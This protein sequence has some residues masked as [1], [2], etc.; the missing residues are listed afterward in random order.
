MALGTQRIRVPAGEFICTTISVTEGHGGVSL[1][2]FSLGVGLVRA[3]FAGESSRRVLELKR[4][5]TR[6]E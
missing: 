1:F 3:E 2:W 5:R 4:Y 6:M